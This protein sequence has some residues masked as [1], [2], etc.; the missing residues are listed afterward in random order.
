MMNS[1]RITFIAALILILVTSNLATLYLNS[2]QIISEGNLDTKDGEKLFYIVHSPKT[3]D[4]KPLVVLIHGFSG[5]SEMLDIMANEL[6]NNGMLTITYDLRG[7]GKSTSSWYRGNLS[8]IFDD[9]HAIVELA[10]REYNARTEMIAVIGHSMGASITQDFAQNDSRIQCLVLLG[11]Q[12]DLNIS[13]KVNILTIIGQYDE[14]T[15]LDQALVAFKNNTGIENPEIGKVYGNFTENNAREYSVSSLSNHLTLLYNS[16][17]IR[18]VV[19]WIA[20]FYQ[21]G[22]PVFSDDLRIGVYLIVFFISYLTIF[23]IVGEF[24]DKFESKN[25]VPEKR[26]NLLWIIPTYVTGSLL[27]S[28]IAIFLFFFFVTLTPLFMSDYILT[29]FYSQI[30]AIYLSIYIYKKIT[31]KDLR[32]LLKTYLVRDRLLWRIVYALIIAGVVYLMNLIALQQFFNVELGIS[33]IGLFVELSILLVPYTIFNEI[34]FRVIANE[35]GKDLFRRI[36][37]SASLRGASL[38]IFYLMMTIT[39]GGTSGFLGLLSI[40]LYA[41]ILLQ[42]SYDLVSA[43]I[44][45]KTHSITEQIIWSTLVYAVILTAISPII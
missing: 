3:T 25:E 23:F 11:S 35:A 22:N 4:P 17:A 7:H 32:S 21:I 33:R 8:D 13:S 44:F 9:F 1:R 2:G 5:S 45:S 28:L 37:F 43:Y 36:L 19:S 41:T 38:I 10:E 15:N 26:F 12:I 16:D 14:I 6:A 31:Q 30:L 40:M 39:F 29:F 20:E 34:F 24:R 42:L 18:K 27:S